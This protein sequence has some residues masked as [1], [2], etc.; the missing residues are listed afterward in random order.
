MSFQNPS[1]SMWV[2][3]SDMTWRT[4]GLMDA[5]TYT[6]Q[7]LWHFYLATI[8]R[9]RQR[10]CHDLNIVYM[11]LWVKRNVI[12]WVSGDFELLYMYEHFLL[13]MRASANFTTR[14]VLSCRHT[15]VCFGVAK[16]GKL[17]QKHWEQ[18]AKYM[19]YFKYRYT[20]QWTR[21]VSRQHSSPMGAKSLSVFICSSCKVTNIVSVVVENVWG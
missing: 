17:Q 1:L 18:C 15:F 13:H 4:H 20:Q 9:A 21:V 12:A 16:L 2:Y 14:K 8:K 10:L 11:W 3:C 5:L 19:K 7:T 6:V